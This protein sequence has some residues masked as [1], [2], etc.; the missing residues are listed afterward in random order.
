VSRAAL[1]LLLLRCLLLLLQHLLCRLQQLVLRLL[2]QRCLLLRQLQQHRMLLH[3]LLL[4]H[5]LLRLLL[6][7]HCLPRLDECQQQSAGLLTA[8]LEA[9]VLMSG[10][11]SRQQG[12][13]Q[14]RAGDRPA[15]PLLLGRHLAL[16]QRWHP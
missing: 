4:R 5:L 2:L 7:R 9:V 13:G 12:Q 8:L 14:P 16:K 1:L 11:K 3:D 6:L 10:L 15:W